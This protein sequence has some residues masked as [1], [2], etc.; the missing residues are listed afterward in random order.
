MVHDTE[1][2]ALVD[3]DGRIFASTDQWE[4]S[5]PTPAGQILV[6]DSAHA[7]GRCSSRPKD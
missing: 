5:N 6:K 1:T 7:R 4:Y 3:H 2:D